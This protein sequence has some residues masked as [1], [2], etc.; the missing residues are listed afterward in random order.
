MDITEII[1]NQ[2][3]FFNTGKTKDVPFIKET[4]KKLLK[5]IEKREE[6]ILQALY[7][8]FKK[9]F[10]ESV[11]TETELVKKEL[12]E[13][14]K[15]IKKWHKPKSVKPNLLNFPSSAKIYNEPY[16]SVLI[17]SPWNY[18][19]QLAFNPLIG[20]ISAGNTVVL[21][22]S[23]LTPNTSKITREI[24]E[25]TFKTEHI[26]VIEGGINISQEL[27]KQR[28]DYIFFTGS[29]SVGKIVYQSASKNLTPVTL[30]LGGKNPCIIDETANINLSAK[31]ITW[32]KFINAG[33]TCIAPDYLL[34]HKSIKNIFVDA[35]KKEIENFYGK[36]IQKSND[37][38]R[39]ININHFNR[40]TNLLKNQEI[41]FGGK[42][43]IN[44]LFI[45][46]TLINEPNLESDLMNDEIFAPI[47]P[48]ISYETEE[49]INKVITKF[50]KPLALYI[51]SNRKDF[52]KKLINKYSFGGGT[53]NDTT[54]HFTN[55]SLP[56]GGVGYSGIG[57]YHG[58]QTFDVF[59]HKKG[60]ITRGTWLDIPIRYAPYNKKIKLL[61]HL[62][63]WI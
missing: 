37:F 42:N 16:G 18:P 58:K 46:P 44:D 63:K 62:M 13:F 23:E 48:I 3:T 33:Q 28:W 4:L 22:P 11:M 52:A 19:F 61:K 26:A 17:I 30:E 50:E 32:G 43:D 15:N 2:K 14:I 40:A 55:K 36:D 49:D 35:L 41:L 5:E 38:A 1:K 60:V 39:I 8:D 25:S 45:G 9:P 57:S 12:K 59:S 51:F 10:F 54:V 31:R 34:I 21:K 24:I 56:F 7:N 47:L 20:A 6:D 53:I 29:V 27:L